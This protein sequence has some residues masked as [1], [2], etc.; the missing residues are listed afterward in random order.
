MSVQNSGS[1]AQGPWYSAGLRFTCTGCGVCCSGRGR[2]WLTEP[3]I[4]QLAGELKV[5]PHELIERAVERV[6]GRWAL[7]EDPQ[8]GDCTFLEGRRCQVYQGRPRQCRTFPWWPSTLKSEASWVEVARVCEGVDAEGA[9]LVPLI[10]I[11]ERLSE[12]RSGRAGR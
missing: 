7:K 3:D 6:E 9:P 2:V 12:E 10:Q 11:E 4:Y 5:E 8:T 1:G